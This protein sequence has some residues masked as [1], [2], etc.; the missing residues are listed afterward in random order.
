MQIDTEFWDLVDQLIGS[1]R[2]VI[3]RPR[4][5]AHPRYPELIYP[6]DY[7]YLEDTTSGDG[8]GIDL[9]LGSL[10]ERSATGLLC[11]VDVLKRDMEIKLLIGCRPEEIEIILAFM[12]SGSM[13]RTIVV[14]R[15]RNSR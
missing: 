2:I 13:M 10:G 15:Q 1:S 8:Q 9:W 11:S 4:G 5:T 7:G 12:N 6:L 14:H 3:D